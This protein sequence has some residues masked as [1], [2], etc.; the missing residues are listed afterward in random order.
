MIMSEV[1]LLLTIYNRREFTLRW[2]QFIK[3][4]NCPFNI[5]IC[6]GGNDQLLERK[7][8]NLVKNN[9]KIKYKKF[10]YYK[11]YEKFFE[12]FY[13]ATKDIKTKYT[14]LCEDDD[15][16][17][18]EN[19]KKSEYF[20]N[21]NNDYSSSGGQSFNVEILQNNFLFARKEHIK[22]KSYKDNSKFKRILKVLNN[23]QSN[24]NCLHRT[25]NLNKVF[26][27]MHKIDF[28]NLYET[29]LLFVLGSLYFG[30]VNR[31]NHIEYVKCDNTEYSSSNHFAYQYKCHRLSD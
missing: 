7:L 25:L 27:M 17:I 13:L 14:Y 2:I 16:I 9:S 20:L 19:I 23:M 6:D 4:F 30:K 12:K 21:K 8:K 15:F 22:S 10:N 5:Y 18:F 11:N 31:F 26:E 29:E 3:E 24:Y 1:T 28:K